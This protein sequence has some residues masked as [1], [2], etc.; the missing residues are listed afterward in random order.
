MSSDAEVFR[1]FLQLFEWTYELELPP[2]HARAIETELRI[3][4]ANS[5]PSEQELVQFVLQ[6]YQAVT[7]TPKTERAAR[8]REVRKIMAGL[9]SKREANDRGRVLDAIHR[10]VESLRPGITGVVAPGASMQPLS[11]FAVPSA[12]PPT[13]AISTFVA[14]AAMPP[15]AAMSTFGPAAA[16]AQAFAPATAYPGYQVQQAPPWAVNPYGP[17]NA[18]QQQLLDEQARAAAHARQRSVDQQIADARERQRDIQLKSTLAAIEHET[19]MAVIRNM[20]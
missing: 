20:K 18:Q 17:P 7:R 2:G 13:A 15:T 12:M 1:A 11:T 3:G 19:C 9:F 6:M 14:P 5:D 10:A 8:R 4:W 16:P